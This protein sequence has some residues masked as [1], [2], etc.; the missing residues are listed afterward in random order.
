MISFLIYN[1]NNFEEKLKPSDLD[2][3]LE[4]SSSISTYKEMKYKM[5]LNYASFNPKRDLIKNIKLYKSFPAELEMKDEYYN[6]DFENIMVDIYPKMRKG[7]KLD[8]SE[9]P[10]KF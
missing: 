10:L 8:L 3:T 9:F 6:T 2:I 4:T 1:K 7:I 5:K